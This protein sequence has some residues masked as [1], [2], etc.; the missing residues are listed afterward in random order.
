MTFCEG[1]SVGVNTIPSNLERVF[2]YDGLDHH[3]L[4]AAG[5]DG[6]VRRKSVGRKVEGGG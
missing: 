5:H 3:T 2:T 6:R 1:D 4:L